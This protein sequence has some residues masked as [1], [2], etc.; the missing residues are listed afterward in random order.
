MPF[1]G[2]GLHILVALY[3]AVHAIRS[4]QQMYWLIILFSFPMLGSVAYFFAIYLPNSR[5]EHG[6][7]KVV[8]AAAKTLDPGKEVREA[9]AAF[10]YTPTAQNQ[11][12]LAAALLNNGMAEESAKNYDACLKGPFAT[13]LEIRLGAA[14]AYLACNRANE[15]IEHLAFIRQTDA[16]FRAEQISLLTA[17]ALAAAGRQPEARAEFEFAVERF[18]SFECRAEYAIWAAT[19]GQ[20]ELALRLRADVQHSMARWSRHTREL[21]KSLVRRLNAAFDANRSRAL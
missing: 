3:F 17:Q 15:A 16:A 8:H 7:R 13:D 11:M 20:S 9:R 14:G 6:A 21:N 19:T 10:D 18:G 5:L 12:R 2:L 1:V 4:G